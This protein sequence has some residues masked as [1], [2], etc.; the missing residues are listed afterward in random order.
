MERFFIGANRLIKRI[1]SDPKLSLLADII[2]MPL[3][4]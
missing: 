2:E 3:D 4:S 1:Y